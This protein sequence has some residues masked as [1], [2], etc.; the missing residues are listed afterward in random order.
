MTTDEFK[1][2]NTGVDWQGMSVA[3]QKNLVDELGRDR[4][5]LKTIN[6][7]AVE[8]IAIPSRAELAWYLAREVVGKLGFVDCIVYYLDDEKNVLRQQAAIGE[9]KNPASNE[10]VNILEIP[11][12]QGITGHVAATKQAVIVDDLQLDSRYIPDIDPARSEIC[13]PLLIDGRLA[14]VIDCEDPRVGHFSEFHLE[15][16]TTIA[17]MTSAKLKLIEQDQTVAMAKKLA[18]SEAQLRDFGA[19]ASDWYWEMDANLKFSYFSDSFTDVT[20]TAQDVLLGRTWEEIGNPGTDAEQWQRHLDILACHR[21]FR[22]FVHS[23]MLP[24]G[25]VVWLSINGKPVADADG[26]FQGYRGTGLD[27]SE[28]RK[29][30]DE[31]IQAKEVAENASRAKSAFLSSM[32]HEMRTPLN[33]VLGFAQLLKSNP[34]RPLSESEDTALDFILSGGRHLLELVNQVLD[35]NEIETGQLPINI[36]PTL[37]SEV[38]DKSL[39][40]ILPRANAAGIE[41]VNRTAADELPRLRTD[42]TRLMQILVNL[43]SNAVKYN[44]PGGTVTVSCQELPDHLLRIVVADTGQGIPAALQDDLF[45]P[46]ERLGREAG[47]IEGTGIGLTIAKQITDRLEGRIGFESEAGRGSTF[48]VDIPIER[49]EADGVAESHVG[50]T[51]ACAVADVAIRRV[52]Y[53]EDN[54]ANMRLM[55]AIFTVLEHTELLTAEN[56]ERG[57]DVATS[58]R[59]DLIL[60]D[61][62]MPG[63][64]G[65]E[66][67]KRLQGAPETKDIPVIAVSTAA[68]PKEVE[69]GL[70]AGFKAYV[71]KPFDVATLV[72]TVEET[73]AAVRG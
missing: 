43:L 59:P 25:K 8:L 11:V 7:F 60:M 71:S 16:L 21:P 56:A 24:G 3:E 50:L 66:A 42:P 9:H 22:N 26:R 40:L 39:R 45:K 63:M 34:D 72:N 35:L 46:F 36:E 1:D 17:A 32:S 27:I 53:I 2:A 41:I 58:E 61:I 52:L 4:S 15:I 37:A 5:V 48:W 51:A 33:A 54:L 49:L 65:F 57:I 18:E 38:I 62:N 73:L 70:R 69:T 10:I 30:Q 31:L 19:S 28:L 47:D 13:V 64:N 68:M 20:G 23:R 12:G 6:T 44:R 14:G 29:A 67:L 55:E